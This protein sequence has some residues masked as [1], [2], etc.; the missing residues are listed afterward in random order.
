MPQPWS[1]APRLN[2]ER[3]GDWEGRSRT[4]WC[5]DFWQ[6]KCPARGWWLGESKKFNKPSML[7][8]MYENGPK[9]AD[10]LH[11]FLLKSTYQNI[12]PRRFLR[13]TLIL[14]ILVT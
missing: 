13:N 11:F 8:V 9:R 6:G 10:F 5:A 7:P 14:K 12:L 1:E 3:A 2:F 4:A